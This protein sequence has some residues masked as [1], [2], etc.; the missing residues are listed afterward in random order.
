MTY[1]SI[2][3]LSSYDLLLQ[4]TELFQIWSENLE[5]EKIRKHLYHFTFCSECK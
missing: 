4:I 2:K 3:E 5:W 1:S